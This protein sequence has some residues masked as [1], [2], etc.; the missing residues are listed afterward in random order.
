[1]ESR[2]SES[3]DPPSID[4]DPARLFDNG[5]QEPKDNFALLILNQ[6]V[7]NLE[8]FKPLWE[9]GIVTPIENPRK[10]LTRV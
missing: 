4:W 5:S 6:P 3:K 9:K 8:T 10:A 2:S 7:E 1:M